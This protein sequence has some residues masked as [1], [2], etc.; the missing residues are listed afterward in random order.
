VKKNRVRKFLSNRKSER[1][2]QCDY[3]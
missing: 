1:A 2:E 3:Y